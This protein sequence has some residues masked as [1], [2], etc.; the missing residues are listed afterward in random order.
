MAYTTDCPICDEPIVVQQDR[1]D[2]HIL[3]EEHTECT[4]CNLYYSEYVT[5]GTAIHL[6]PFPGKEY[7]T[8]VFSY[9]SLATRQE[10]RIYRIKEKATRILWQLGYRRKDKDDE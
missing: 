10:W 3:L 9:N 4:N 6:Y 1:L 2:G 7:A 8:L 5:G